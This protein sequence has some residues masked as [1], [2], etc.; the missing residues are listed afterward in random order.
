MPR[1]GD[2]SDIS[3]VLGVDLVDADGH[4]CEYAWKNLHAADGVEAAVEGSST[5]AASGKAYN[6]RYPK[7]DDEERVRGTIIEITISRVGAALYDDLLAACDVDSL[8]E[9]KLRHRWK[10][11]GFWVGETS[12]ALGDYGPPI[13]APSGD[14]NYTGDEER[15]VTVRVLVDTGGFTT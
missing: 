9:T 3:T 15:E 14:H 6:Q 12:P 4:E 5:L 13:S 2:T 8:R 1:G 10:R 7:G 11:P